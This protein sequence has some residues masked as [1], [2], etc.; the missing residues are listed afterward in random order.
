[1]GDLKLTDALV[2]SLNLL[3]QT[4]LLLLKDHLLCQLFVGALS[5]FFKLGLE[6]NERALVVNPLLLNS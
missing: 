4:H 2:M 5:N 1:V 3:V 6:T